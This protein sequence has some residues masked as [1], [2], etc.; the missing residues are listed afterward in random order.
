MGIESKYPRVDENFDPIKDFTKA[1]TEG[2]ASFLSKTEMLDIRDKIKENYDLALAYEKAREKLSGG[3]KVD[4]HRGVL[5][6]QLQQD[7]QSDPAAGKLLEEFKKIVREILKQ[8]S[9]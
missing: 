1:P 7:L 4:I 6:N 3:H 9:E 8:S 5:M 2:I